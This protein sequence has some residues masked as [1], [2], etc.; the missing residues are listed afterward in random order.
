MPA[1][2]IIAAATNRIARSSAAFVE[3]DLRDGNDSR[4]NGPFVVRTLA[5]MV[6]AMASIQ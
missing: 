3:L 4:Q 1:R 6:T 5:P 2:R